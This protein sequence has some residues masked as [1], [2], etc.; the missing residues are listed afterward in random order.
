MKK[1]L[2]L[3]VC[4]FSMVVAY[5]Q[6]LPY[7]LD[8]VHNNPGE[9]LTETAFNDPAYLK[10]K[11]YNGQVM[12]DFTF[13][14][15]AITFDKLNPQIFPQG[16]KERAWVMA[17]A[18]RVRKN[19]KAAH[20][21]GIKVYYFTDLIVLPKKL[22]ELYH[23][24]IC[25]ANGKIS[26]ARPKTIEIHKL[27]L[28][29]LFKTFPDLDGLVIR[30]GETYLNNVPYHTGNNPIT[31]GVASHVTLINLLREEVCEKR[32]KTI[33]YRTWSFGGM[34]DS[35]DYYLAVTNQITQHKNLIFSIKHT[36][37]DYHRTYSFNPTLGIGKHQQ[38]IEVECQREYEGKGA[39][40][41]YVMEGV[42]N[43]FEEY[44]TTNIQ[45]GNKSLNDLKN[46]PNIVGVWSWSRGGGWVGPY[47]T[48]EFWCKLNAFVISK[49]GADRNRTE[50]SVFNSFMDDNGI[51]KPTSRAAFR[52][53]CL[54][55]AKAVLR[56]HESGKYYFDK[57][58]VW[59]M[60]DEF[61]GGIDTANLPQKMFPSEG[62]L[63]QAYDWYYKNGL[64]DKVIEEKQEAVVLWKKIVALS[65]KIEMPN[66]A[67][68][69]YI[70]V[71]SKYGLLLH[72][73]IADGWK[74]MA[75]GYKGDKTGTYDKTQLA[76]TIKKYDEDWAKYN[77]LK[78]ANPS[79]DTLYRPYSFIYVA[80]TFYGKQG[81]AAS[82]DKYRALIE[83]KK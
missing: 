16:S 38:I 45:K 62:F 31:Q 59:W 83:E 32:N 34:H 21:A 48:N 67:D 70:K 78:A 60:R 36:K 42:I 41:D 56:G 29:E 51:T 35:A 20:A 73:I 43:G 10:Q 81:M 61:L 79:C 11:G 52:E 58:W 19:I 7:I 77:Q 44:F 74:I 64:L 76:A 14:H 49:W 2:F 63:L 15:A 3:V 53:L 72:A 27:M 26:F 68:K 82:V 40:P 13:A 66:K 5:S 12:N 37:G 50:E 69:D 24:D 9:P 17:A 25:D 30:T 1:V 75:L 18:D 57:D 54:L 22:V 23:D 8:M 4:L 65:N 33:F 47:I 28:D 71:S 55:S 46:N 80:P 39:H 6:S